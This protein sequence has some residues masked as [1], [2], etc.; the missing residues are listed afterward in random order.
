MLLRE[1]LDVNR[2]EILAR[3]RSRVAARNSPP[4]N[5]AELTHGLPVFLGELGEALRRATEH[6]KIDHEQIGASATQHGDELF[7]KGVTVAQVVHDYG[8]L[9][10]VI[11]GLAVERK[12]SVEAG[13]FRT[14]NLCLDDAIAGA[15]TAWTRQ[16]ERVL[17]DEG[18][19]R[20]GV[21]A[22]EMRNLLSTAMMS[23]TG[24]RT[25]VVGPSGST[26]A[27]LERS[28]I[29]LVALVDRSLAD[30]RLDAGLQHVE[31]ISVCD[32]LAEV[33]IGAMFICKKR[34]LRFEVT[35]VDPTVIVRADA[36]ILAATV[37]NLLQNAIKFT[38]KGTTVKLRASTTTTRVLI[39]VEDECG[40]LPPGYSQNL[41]KP[42][43]Q[44]GEDRT[45]LGLGLSICF[46]AM[47]AIGGELRVEDLPRKG[48]IFTI[49]LPKE[50]P[51]P[52]S[53]H[54]H[55]GKTDGGSSVAGGQGAS[56]ATRATGR[57]SART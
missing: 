57:A 34:G 19:E 27:V 55:H 40:G 41:L 23:F 26:G 36:Q 33:E 42:F 16:R 12:A 44:Q 54:A 11:T 50:P 18:T 1:F 17:A 31:H 9:C 22:H 5:D 52:T 25:G 6:E 7:R 39:E 49:D 53:I 48:C 43:N 24:I 32:V 37:S 10:Q 3:S 45:G 47:K 30:V 8:D 28:L 21:L 15:V 29:G 4:V 13:E 38:R 56:A 14:L 35:T 51:P 46:K 2:E 20:L